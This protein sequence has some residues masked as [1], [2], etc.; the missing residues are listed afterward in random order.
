MTPA[1]SARPQLPPAPVPASSEARHPH[2]LSLPAVRAAFALVLLATLPSPR[3]DAQTTGPATADAAG[4]LPQTVRDLL[5]G[6]TDHAF[7]FDQPGFFAVLEHVQHTPLDPG[8]SQPPLPL[9]DWRQPLERPGDFRGAV[10]T[11]EGVVGRNSNWQFT[12]ADRRRRYGT[13]W[14]IELHRPDM[15]LACTLICTQDVSEIGLGSTIR[16]TGYFVMARQYPLS[17]NR[18]GHALLLVAKGPHLVERAAPPRQRD[19]DWTNVLIGVAG[20]LLLAILVLARIL[21]RRSSSGRRTDLH[22]LRSTREPSQNLADE[23][24]DWADRQPPPSDSS[25]PSHP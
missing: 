1:S 18:T 16:A 9:D 12:D 20:A 14:Q 2:A 7:S 17:G 22:T 23:L 8:Y 11:V 4:E 15:P 10:L 19:V 24:A 13:V 21:S 3:L 25:D 5:A 6:V